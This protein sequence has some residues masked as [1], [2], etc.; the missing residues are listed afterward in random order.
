MD[1]NFVLLI[2]SFFVIATLYSSVGF[3]GG[4]SYLA[5]LAL[6][7]P[8]FLE[9]KST[10]LL[11]NLVVVSGGTYLFIKEGLFNLKKFLPLALC[12]VPAAFLGAMVPLKQASFFIC[13][14]G[15]L[16]FSGFLLVLQFF[17]QPVAQRIQ[18]GH[19][20]RLF[21]LL[22]GTGSGFVSGLVGIG[23]GILL[24][25][26]LHL[27]RW[28]DARTIAA[29]ASFFILVNSIA[30]L[31][32]QVAGG[33]FKADLSLLAPLLL[34]VLVGGQ[35]GTRIS[36]RRIKPQAVKGL[37]GVFVLFIGL[38]LVFSYL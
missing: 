26:V 12:S 6:F 5:L 16:A 17:T 11:C 37:T 24:S 21:N 32:G 18:Y 15:V 10:A 14:G 38:K 23:G 20:S 29:L 22:L 2:L 3:G 9:I 31:L 25:P 34:A 7:L 4:S 19:H 33:N 1:W 27:L 8:N 36:L 35:L 28:A 30:G 13:L